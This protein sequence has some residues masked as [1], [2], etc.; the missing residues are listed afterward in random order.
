MAD[1]SKPLTIS[2]V[3]LD[4]FFGPGVKLDFRGRGVIQNK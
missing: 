3:P 2:E 4:W 1:G